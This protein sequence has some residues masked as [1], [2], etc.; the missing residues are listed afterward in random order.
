MRSG[1]SLHLTNIRNEQVGIDT[2][3]LA[4]KNAFDFQFLSNSDGVG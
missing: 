1:M 3:A 4:M 2:H